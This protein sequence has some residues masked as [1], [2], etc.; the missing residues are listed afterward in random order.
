MDADLK[1]QLD[2][3][4]QKLEATYIA[5]QKTRSYIFWTLVITAVVII[6]PL[7]IL[8]FAISSLLG[9]YSSALNM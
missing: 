7:L 6:V 4:E 8:P 3:I 9:S 1:A 2:R 5:A